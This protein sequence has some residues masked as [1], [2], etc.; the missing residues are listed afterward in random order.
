VQ[1]ESIEC[2]LEQRLADFGGQ[3]LETVGDFT[4]SLRGNL[5]VL[6]EAGALR[7][8]EALRVLFGLNR[9]MVSRLSIITTAV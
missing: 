7:L 5:F 9:R 2:K 1:A 3:S 8:C 6:G 4:N